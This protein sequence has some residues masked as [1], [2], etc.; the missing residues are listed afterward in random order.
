MKDIPGKNKEEESVLWKHSKED[1]NGE[2]P[3]YIFKVKEKHKSAFSRQ[4]SEG[5]NILNHNKKTKLLNRKTEFNAAKIPTLEVEVNGNNV[6]KKEENEKEE[7]KRREER[8]RRREGNNNNS[9]NTKKIKAENYDNEAQRKQQQQPTTNAVKTIGPVVK[10]A[11]T[12]TYKQ[13]QQQ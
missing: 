6:K 7:E 5:M 12:T 10:T 1:H 9:N 8:K 2:V 11:T 4:I 13:Q 3:E